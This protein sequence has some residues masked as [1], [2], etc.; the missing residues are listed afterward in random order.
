MAAVLGLCAGCFA[1]DGLGV[2]LPVYGDG[3]LPVPGRVGLALPAAGRHDVHAE[4]DVGEVDFAADGTFVNEP[5]VRRRWT[6]QFGATVH[7][8]YRNGF[9]PGVS[10]GTQVGNNTFVVSA[11]LMPLEEDHKDDGSSTYRREDLRLSYRRTIARERWFLEGSVFQAS[12]RAEWAGGSTTAEAIRGSLGIGWRSP[13]GRSS[14][15]YSDA[16]VSFSFGEDG[17][18]A[19]AVGWAEAV[20]IAD[21]SGPTIRATLVGLSF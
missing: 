12:A 15:V 19:P 11:I 10:F 1:T 14:Y 3:V 6:A 16:S 8:D 20:Y 17:A 7:I 2:D 13:W 9:V 4:I 5:V 21:G 18:V